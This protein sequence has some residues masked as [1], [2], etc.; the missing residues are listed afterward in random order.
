MTTGQADCGL[1]M[2]VGRYSGEMVNILN[3]LI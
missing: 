2:Q 3:E 1:L